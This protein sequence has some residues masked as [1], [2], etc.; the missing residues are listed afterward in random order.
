MKKKE[1]IVVGG[2]LAGLSTAMRLAEVG[3]H[4]KLISITKVKR[5]HSVCAQGGINAAL[6]LKNEGDSPLI[7]AYETLKGGDFLANQPPVVE[8]CLAAP[9]IIRMMDR[10]GC[11]FNRTAEGNIDVRRFGGSLFH[12]TVFCG[13][14]TGQQ[15]LYTLDEQVRR[16]E[17]AGLIEKFENHEFMRLCLD[18][19]GRACGIVMMDHFNMKLEV[20]KADAVVVATGGLGVLFRKSTNSIFCTGAANG[21]LYLQG[22]Q[23]ANGEFI[24][25]HPTAIVGE[26]K[27]RLMSESS[28][29]E[30][31]R[32]WVY[33][34]SDKEYVSQDGRRVS[35]GV[36]GKPWYFLEELYPIYGNLVTRDIASREILRVCEQGFGVNGESQVYLDVSHL[37]AEKLKKLQ[38]ILD[39]YQKF[40][41]DDPSKVAMKIF[42]A[43]HYSM[44][45]AWVDWPAVDDPQ[46]LSR[47]RQ[48]TNLAGCF[49]CGES[50]Y[51]YHGA[52]RLGANSLLSCIFGGLV[53]AHEVDRF[54]DNNA[55]PQEVPDSLFSKALQQEEAK[56]AEIFSRKG[57]ENSYKL[58]DELAEWMVKYVTVTRNNEDLARTLVK[59]K[60]L[61]ERHK[62]IT[63][64]DEGRFANQSYIF[65]NQF[66]PMLEIAHVITKCALLRNES[67]GSH[68]KEG[69]AKRDDKEW[70]KTS[71]ATW[72]PATQEPDVT[73]ASVDTR[74]VEPVLR[75]Y[76]TLPKAVPHFENLPQEIPLPV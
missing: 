37:S 40:T 15:L 4:V 50:D 19:Q 23:Y 71:I 20:V 58:Y 13:A 46:R 35:A 68:A 29:G 69:F 60:E 3:I 10:L 6:N 34:N 33:G 56:R 9:G 72:N 36:T 41:G 18:E 52:N 17:V 8:M 76:S 28:R 54:I 47:Y 57:P 30:G 39:T 31:G 16:H 1:V 61:R 59:I 45:G 63:L 7:H 12:R 14:S 67:R 62:N 51:L 25:I 66:E 22:M 27:M 38:A 44:G 53:T 24:Q 49:N 2:G 48:M 70:L 75:D 26:D 32:L 65:A 21:R 43:V 5:S 64:G 42:P 55:L 73:Y 74:Y 11:P